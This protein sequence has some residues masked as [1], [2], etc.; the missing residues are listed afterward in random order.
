MALI[1]NLWIIVY[2]ILEILFKDD[3]EKVAAILFGE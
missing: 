3:T 2:D 1:Y